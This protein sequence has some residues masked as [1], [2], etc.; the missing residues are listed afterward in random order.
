MSDLIKHDDR[1]TII[2]GLREQLRDSREEVRAAREELAGCRSEATAANK[3]VYNLRRQLQPLYSALQ[4]VFGEIDG[5]DLAEAPEAVS[6][7]KKSAAWESWKSRLGGATAKA[8][9]I[10]ML[11]GELNHGQLRIHLGCATRTVTN[12]VTALNK[13]QLINKNGGK[14]S[15]KEL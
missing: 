10:L 2:A 4:Q 8:I 6:T 5:M 11:H 1:D 9:D 12:V 14:I 15:L 13:Y 3:G 7:T